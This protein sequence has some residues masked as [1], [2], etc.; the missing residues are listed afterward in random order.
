VSTRADDLDDKSTAVT[1]AVG[2]I[3]GWLGSFPAILLSLGIVIAWFAGAFFVAH[4]FAN[5]TY[6]LL[7][8]TG[9]TIITFWMVFIIQN[10]QNRDGRAMQAKLDAQTQVLCAI[11]ERLGVDANTGV[12]ERLVGLEDAPEHVIKED[13][14]QVRANGAVPRNG[15]STSNEWVDGGRGKASPGQVDLPPTPSSEVTQQ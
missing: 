13:Q 14:Q 2:N 7:I 4:R 1:R 6:Q 5:D 9:T 12:L 8:N 11:A 10:T 15:S 3:T